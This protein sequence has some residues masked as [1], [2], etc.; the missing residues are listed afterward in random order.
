L[1]KLWELSSW[2]TADNH[3]FK[4]ESWPEITKIK[5]FSKETSTNAGAI[6]RDI[7]SKVHWNKN[8][9]PIKFHDNFHCRTE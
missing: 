8:S 7:I 1:V 5:E 3:C 6:S 9:P 4:K 2:L